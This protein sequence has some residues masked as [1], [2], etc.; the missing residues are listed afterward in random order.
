MSP[1]NP[2]TVYIGQFDLMRSINGGA[3]WTPLST[4]KIH[5]DQHALAFSPVDPN[6][7]FIGNDGGLYKT[8]NS[9]Q[10]YQ[11][12]NDTLSLTQFYGLTLHPTDPMKTFGGT[13]DN[14]TEVR[15]Q[16]D[17]R[18]RMI[19]GGDGGPFIINPLDPRTV[20]VSYQF[21]F[22]WRLGDGGISFEAV[23]GSPDIFG[24]GQ[25]LR[26]AFIPPFTGNGVDPNLYF[27]TWRLF[28]STDLG[29]SWTAPAGNLDLTKGEWD[30]LSTISVA[31][32]DP[33]TIYTGSAQGR[34]MVTTDGGFNWSDITAGLP[35]RYISDITID[36]DNPAVAYLSVSGYGS[37]HVFKTTDRGASWVDV[38]GNLPDIPTNALL[39]DP[40]NKNIIYA[41][42]DIGVFRSTSAGN[43]W[44]NLNNGM[45]PAVVFALAALPGGLIRLATHGRG[46]YELT[47]T[48]RPLANAVDEDRYFVAQQYL[49]FLNRPPDPGGLAY[50]TFQL[51]ECARDP[52]CIHSRRIGVSAA[53]FIELEF[54]ET[55]YVVY[56]MHRAAFG[57]WP[58][59]PNRAN[60]QFTQF[61]A[62]RGQLVA[63][64][65]LPGSTIAFANNFVQRAGFNQVY[66]ATLTNEQF[67]NKLFDMAGLTPY[68]A[69]R[70]EQIEAM[71]NGGKTRAQV[72][73]SV[74][75][76][77]AFKEREHN[78][79]FVL[80]QYF[81]YLRRD[82]DQGGYSFWLDVLNNR[83]PGNFRGMVC[84]FLT[85][86]EYQR[87]FGPV[88]TR[89]DRDC[90]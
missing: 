29:N 35:N 90:G 48:G 54:Q 10:T 26:V 33:N 40:T 2:N 17:L 5:I 34:V 52:L 49:D 1:T 19:A 78:G 56:R 38:S 44:E 4:N 66:P 60:L 14:G 24:E 58:N 23:V 65:G 74:I 28:V 46:V 69:E 11:S 83:V 72:L 57:T 21:G 75:D 43:N 71:N 39:V 18:W 47:A 50:W 22:I 31:R 25:N 30:V 80:M 45:P 81:G 70:Q 8:T 89:T 41:G 3:T 77:Q 36:S 79:A 37:A 16:P 73:L 6:V 67:V 86:P 7:M 88:V 64:P 20:F 55:G 84:A 51:T 9:G 76:T 61:M 27:G 42:T 15:E 59:A 12:L 87:R 13:Q 53:F 32:T 82:P 62:D 85:S 68:T 63:G